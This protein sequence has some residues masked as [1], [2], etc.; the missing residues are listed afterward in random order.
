MVPAEGPALIDA[1]EDEVIYE[2]MF[3]LPN[4]GLQQPAI[5]PGDVAVIGPDI[6]P[7]PGDE[8]GECCYP[9]WSHR[10]VVG[11][12]PYNQYAPPMT[13]LQFGEVRAHR[14]VVEANRLARMTNE[15][16]L[17]ATTTYNALVSDMID[18]TT[19]ISDTKLITDSKE[20]IKVWG[21]VMT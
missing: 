14:S 17:M 18:N 6:P 5:T 10:S 21:Y 19:H 9:L 11:Q 7:P 15:E 16:Q 2:L 13:F 8:A 12:Q 20:E 1:D 3:N 4:A